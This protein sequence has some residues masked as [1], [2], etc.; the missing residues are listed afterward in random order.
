MNKAL[1]GIVGEEHQGFKPH[2]SLNYCLDILKNSY[3][4]DY[5][6]IGTAEVAMKRDELLKN[7][8]GIWSAPGSPF[9]SLQ[10][11][12]YAVEYARVND[13]PHLGTCAG[14]QHAILEYA[15]NVLGIE[16]AQH[17][18]YDNEA[19]VLFVSKLA[20][21]TAGQSMKVSIKAG[22]KVSDLYGLDEVTED[23]YC[24]FGISP[25][26][27]NQVESPTLTVSG[28][29]QDGEIRIIEYPDNRF[30]VATLFVP[31]S[32]FT[33]EYQHP[34]IRGFVEACCS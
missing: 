16:E 10:G 20:C 32:T 9:E 29:D 1:I 11:A 2:T 19:S 33:V 23:Y 27:K 22:T 31:Q 24:N 17:E 26:F 8:S 12:L 18:E 14:F 5:E 7:Y 30:F 13:V 21:S 28:T 15:R 34:I 25:E 3:D 4:F 6:W